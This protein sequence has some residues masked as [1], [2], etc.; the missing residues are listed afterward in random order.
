MRLKKAGLA[1]V[2]VDDAEATGGVLGWLI[3]PTAFKC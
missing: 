2:D 1:R 3:P